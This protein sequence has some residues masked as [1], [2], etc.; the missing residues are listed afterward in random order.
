[1]PKTSFGQAFA[2]PLGAV[3]GVVIGWAEPWI[4]PGMQRLIPNGVRILS[5][6]ASSY[7]T[8]EMKDESLQN[9][10]RDFQVRLDPQA[11]T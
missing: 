2:N 6:V 9:E 8:R 3:D 10:S 7:Q 5:L 4:S 11:Q 1:M